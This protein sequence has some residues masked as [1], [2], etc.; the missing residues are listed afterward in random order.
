MDISLPERD[1][2][3]AANKIRKEFPNAKII[4]MTA[5]GREWVQDTVKLDGVLGTL[6]KPFKAETLKTLLAKF[7]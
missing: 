7:A 5:F 1:G 2:D 3:D 4:F 6:H